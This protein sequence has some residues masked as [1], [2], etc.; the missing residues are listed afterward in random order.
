MAKNGIRSF[1]P[2]HNMIVHNFL[3]STKMY[4]LDSHLVSHLVFRSWCCCVAMS[5]RWQTWHRVATMPDVATCCCHGR[6]G[7]WCCCV[8]TSAVSLTRSALFTYY[9]ANRRMV[10]YL[11]SIFKLKI[12]ICNVYSVIQEAC[13]IQ[14]RKWLEYIVGVTRGAIIRRF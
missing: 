3:L 2:I 8:A 7:T 11:N 14:A 4:H 10:Y 6:R 9:L 1:V 12:T 13:N 5:A